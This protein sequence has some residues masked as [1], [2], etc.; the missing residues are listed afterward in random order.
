MD[1]EN[2]LFRLFKYPRVDKAKKP[3]PTIQPYVK[4]IVLGGHRIRFNVRGSTSRVEAEELGREREF[5]TIFLD[6]IEE[7]SIV[8]DVGA[9][10]GLYGLLAASTPDIREVNLFEPDP[11][12]ISLLNQNIQLNGFECVN[13]HTCAVADYDGRAQLLSSG[14]GEGKSPRLDQVNH[15]PADDKKYK[16]KIDVSVAKADSLISSGLDIP[17]VIK[18]DIEGAE[19]LFLD[20]SE[21]MFSGDFGRRPEHVFIELHSLLLPKNCNAQTIK[22]RFSHLGYKLIR[23]F[24]RKSEELCYFKLQ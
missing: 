22:S 3:D 24:A 4:D 9:R 5:L 23:S 2:T 20:G 7:Q 12:N 19:S 21:K 11:A 1:F 13:V 17:H 8:W 10:H 14:S 15:R 16:T 6:V 18:V